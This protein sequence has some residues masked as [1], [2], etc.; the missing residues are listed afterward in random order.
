MCAVRCR[1]LFRQHRLEQ[2][3]RLTE[4]HGPAFELTQ[5][6]EHL[7]GSSLLELLADFFCR[8]PTQPFAE[9]EC[10]AAGK[11]KRQGGE[12]GTATQGRARQSV[13]CYG[14]L[15]VL[16][17]AEPNGSST[18]SSLMHSIVQ[19][20]ANGSRIPVRWPHSPSSHQV[21]LTQLQSAAAGFSCSPRKKASVWVTRYGRRPSA[22]CG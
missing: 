15:G 6:P 8:C 7:F 2:T 16:S 19:P 3:E 13:G 5:D 9:T 18:R 17:P 11:A 1:N 14:R 22:E 20:K 12:A 10:G 4:L 21:V